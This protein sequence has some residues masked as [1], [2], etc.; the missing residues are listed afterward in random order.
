MHYLC[1]HNIASIKFNG[2]EAL[3]LILPEPFPAGKTV[4]R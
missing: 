1:V 4:I 3:F 2:Y